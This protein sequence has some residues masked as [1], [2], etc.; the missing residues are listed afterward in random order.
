MYAMKSAQGP[1]AR[2]QLRKRRQGR[3]RLVS[4]AREGTVYTLPLDL[5]PERKAPHPIPYQG[6]KRLLAKHILRFFP[7]D[8]ALLMEPFAGSAAV[9]IAAAS[10]GRC[11][12]FHLNDINKPLMALW[13]DIVHHPAVISDAYETLWR[14]QVGDENRYYA[15]VRERFNLTGRTDYF[16]YLLARCVKASVRYNSS[17]KFNQSPDNRRRGRSPHEMRDDIF[18]VSHLFSRRARLS[19]LDYRKVLQLATRAD[20]VYMDPPY[21]GTCGRRDPRYCTGVDFDE[22]TTELHR[23]TGRGVSFILSYDGRTGDRTYGQPL[24]DSLNLHR[25]ELDAGRSSQ[26]TLLGRDDVTYES[27]YLSEPLVM[28]LAK[29]DEKPRLKANAQLSLV[30]D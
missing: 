5:E 14:A 24:P 18:A 13:H 4:C 9:S 8:L 1:A 7:N 10:R 25:I 30:G 16:L 12:R 2:P 11:S 3:L 29:Q 17:G 19:A 27:L 26:A 23:L 28:R 22:F 6:S 20:L 15:W 21:Q